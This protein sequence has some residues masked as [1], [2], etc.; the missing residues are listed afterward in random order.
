MSRDARASGR[1][2][3][4]CRSLTPEAS[5]PSAHT[6]FMQ[7]SQSL[8]PITTTGAVAW[9][10]RDLF[11]NATFTQDIFLIVRND[12]IIQLIRDGAASSDAAPGLLQSTARQVNKLPDH[13]G[14][15]C[16]SGQSEGD[17]SDNGVI[18][19][20]SFMSSTSLQR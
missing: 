3:P 12:W 8:Q 7:Q 15:R 4:S 2:A 9:S 5:R 17:P 19:Y 1:N 6:Y 16:C 20:R 18:K 13:L 14:V 10:T 11:A